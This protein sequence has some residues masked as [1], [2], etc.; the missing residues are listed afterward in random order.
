MKR[1]Q[2][3]QRPNGSSKVDAFVDNPNSPMAWV[4]NL[5]RAARACKT[6]HIRLSR[7]RVIG[8][9]ILLRLFGSLLEQIDAG[10]HTSARKTLDGLLEHIEFT[11]PFTG[12]A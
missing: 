4:L 6:P 3:H 8:M 5:E 2:P 11:K 1:P 12:G 10:D 9:C 7:D